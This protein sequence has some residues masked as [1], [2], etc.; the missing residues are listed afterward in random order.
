MCQVVLKPKVG[1]FSAHFINKCTDGLR[2][3]FQRLTPV[4]WRLEFPVMLLSEVSRPPVLP[5]TSL[6]I[7][8]F[9]SG[10][11]LSGAAPD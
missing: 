10:L 3:R 4:W 7:Q 1:L 5:M 6:E 11:K 9:S 8:I 2:R